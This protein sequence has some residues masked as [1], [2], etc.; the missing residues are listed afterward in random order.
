MSRKTLRIVFFFLLFFED[1]RLSSVLGP[2]LLKFK[3]NFACMVVRAWRKG[4]K[5]KTRPTRG[6][7]LCFAPLGVLSHQIPA[8]Y[9][10]PS[11]RDDLSE[12]TLRR[13]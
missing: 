7:F 4:G 1:E 6:L 8:S 10:L 3:N 2:F 13:T 9:L 11:R 5:R 12:R